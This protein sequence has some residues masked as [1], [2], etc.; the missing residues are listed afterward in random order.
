MTYLVTDIPWLP[1]VVII[2]LLVIGFLLNRYVFF[3]FI[4]SI[5]TSLSTEE[6]VEILKKEACLYKRHRF[7]KSNEVIKSPFE[8]RDILDMLFCLERHEFIE[9]IDLKTHQVCYYW[10]KIKRYMMFFPFTSKKVFLEKETRADVISSYKN[11]TDSVNT[12]VEDTCP[13]CGTFLQPDVVTCPDCDL[14]FI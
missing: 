12:I 2:L 10:V 4:V 6:R 7:F 3:P 1:L 9:A 8:K 11:W 5:F 13:A 14:E